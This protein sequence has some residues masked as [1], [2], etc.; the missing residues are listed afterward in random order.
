M[1]FFLEFFSPTFQK[2][3]VGGFVSQLINNSCLF[4]LILNVP[5]TI[6]QLYKDRSC[7]VEPVL[8]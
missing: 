5:S 4:D 6:F 7:W 3:T 8:S 2:I 1:I